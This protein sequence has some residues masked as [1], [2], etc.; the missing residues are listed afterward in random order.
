MT[1]LS[2]R[3]RNLSVAG[4]SPALASFS[5]CWR[6]RAAEVLLT[7]YR[8]QQVSKG[9][10]GGQ[11]GLEQLGAPRLGERRCP[12]FRAERADRGAR[13]SGAQQGYR[14]RTLESPAGAPSCRLPCFWIIPY[15]RT[16][17]NRSIF[18]EG[19]RQANDYF[20]SCLS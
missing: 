3:L 17:K 7:N 5:Q 18:Y 20:A 11:E 10:K 14:G 1:A 15:P 9:T 13:W 6:R 8:S 16:E 19:S 2:P 12:A 4:I